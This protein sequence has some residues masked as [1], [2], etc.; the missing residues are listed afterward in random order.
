MIQVNVMKRKW[1]VLY[2]RPDGAYEAVEVVAES[3]DAAALKVP[4][5][6]EVI[7]VSESGSGEIV[8]RKGKKE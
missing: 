7:E 2:L 8:M 5:E 6:Y 3:E 1:T 4:R